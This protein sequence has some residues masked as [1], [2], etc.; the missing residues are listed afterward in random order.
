MHTI[1]SNVQPTMLYEIA[2]SPSQPI[3]PPP[4]T[5]PSAWFQDVSHLLNHSLPVEPISEYPPLWSEAEPDARGPLLAWADLD[6]D[7]WEDLCIGTNCFRN[8]RKGG[9]VPF[10]HSPTQA[11]RNEL[12]A[13]IRQ[14]YRGFWRAAAI[15]DFDGDGRQD[16]V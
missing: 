13:A 7:G 11:Q 4:K 1:L 12:P 3:R 14:Q 15:G 9:F 10:N 2:K 5:R 16:F 8:D 6:G